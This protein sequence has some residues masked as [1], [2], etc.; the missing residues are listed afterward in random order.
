MRLPF[1]DWFQGPIVFL[2]VLLL[3]VGLNQPLLVSKALPVGD[4]AADMLLGNTIARE[5]VL[6]L[7]HYSRWQFNHPGPFWFYLNHGF[8]LMFGGLDLTR[9][10]IWFFGSVL[11]NALLITAGSL[12]F[13]NFLFHQTRFG[14]VVFFAFLWLGFPGTEICSIWMPWRIVS[15]YLCF[16]IAVLYVMDGRPGGIWPACFLSGVLI[17]G[18]VT[19][20]LFTLPFLLLGLGMGE[21]R[22]HFLRS[23]RARPHLIAGGLTLFSMALPMLMEALGPSPTNLSQILETQTLIRDMPKPSVSEILHFVRALLRVDE[24]ASSWWVAAGLLGFFGLWQEMEET[25]RKRML[26]AWSLSAGITIGVLIYYGR[27][28]SPLHPFVA[29]FFVMIPV[30]ALGTLGSMAFFSGT[31]AS[32][33]LLGRWARLMMKAPVALLMGLLWGGQERVASVDSN[34]TLAAMVDV[35]TGVADGKPLSL[36][37]AED[38]PWD[39]MAGLLLE[40]DR[41]RV[42]VCTTRWDGEWVF[43]KFHLCT[44]ETIPKW[45]IVAASSCGGLCLYQRDGYGL[46]PVRLP[47]LTPQVLLNEEPQQARFLNWSESPKGVFWT[48]AKASSLAFE[49]KDPSRMEGVLDLHLSTIGPQWVRVAWNGQEIFS[50][51]I[52]QSQTPLRIKVPLEWVYR[53]PNTLSFEVPDARRHSAKDQRT[54]ALKLTQILIR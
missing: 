44:P 48:A 38:Q 18:Y 36:S 39:F 24:N 26:S 42:K 35:L 4:Y 28:P 21:W 47:I 22:T 52:A 10:Q 20:P 16:L 27:T 9:L 15:P 29:Q 43:T 46:R 7:G 23:R 3:L 6:L 12:A 8:E 49:I 41:R 51:R 31:D 37:Y 13:S 33:S 45:E 40:L 50:D 2:L 32:Q 34:V 30:L 54:L 19:M 1:A 5:G 14:F 11:I 25:L 17:H 53:G